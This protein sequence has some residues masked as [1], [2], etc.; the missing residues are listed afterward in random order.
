MNISNEEPLFIIAYEISGCFTKMKKEFS[1][2]GDNFKYSLLS[3]VYCKLPTTG[4]NPYGHNS[5]CF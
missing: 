3:V 2:D 1:T 5:Q 4:Y